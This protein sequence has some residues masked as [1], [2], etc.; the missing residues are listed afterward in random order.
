[1]CSK[2]TGYCF[3]MDLYQGKGRTPV[4]EDVNKTLGSRVVHSMIKHLQEPADHEI[5]MDNFFTSYNLLVIV[6][7]YCCLPNTLNRRQHRTVVR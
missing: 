3:Q 5:Y 1:M 2:I 6:I 4:Q 7:V